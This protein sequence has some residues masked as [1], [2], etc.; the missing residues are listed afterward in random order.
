MRCVAEDSTKFGDLATQLRG[1]LGL[2]GRRVE[3]LAALAAIVMYLDVEGIRHGIRGAFDDG[4]VVAGPPMH[5][6]VL[7]VGPAHQRDGRGAVLQRR[8]ELNVLVMRR[9]EIC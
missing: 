4:P 5:R 2:L 9:A 3:L 8:G 1:Y 6:Y 7:L